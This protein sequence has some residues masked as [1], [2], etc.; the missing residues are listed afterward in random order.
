MGTS[1][2]NNREQVELLVNRFYDKVKN[3]SLLAPVF[4]HVDWPHHLPTM[5]NFWSSILLGD[6]SYNGS[7]MQKHFPLKI[8]TIYFDRW[9][10]LFKS[11][12]DELF[13]GEK[14]EEAK[15]RADAIAGVF[16]YKMGLIGKD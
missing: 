4:N 14:A 13:I 16:Q 5:Y 1:I 12:V 3:D 11:T 10:A 7:P 15:M 6:Q 9:L 8:D 2:I